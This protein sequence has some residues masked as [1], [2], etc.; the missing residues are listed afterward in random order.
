MLV[1]LAILPHL[2]PSS[3]LA[4]C[5][6]FY[7]SSKH[8]PGFLAHTVLEKGYLT[9]H[10]C[11]VCSANDPQYKINYFLYCIVTSRSILNDRTR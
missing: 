11:I 2:L 4:T 1:F 8:F 7:T 3:V 9:S 6:A 5:S 10:T